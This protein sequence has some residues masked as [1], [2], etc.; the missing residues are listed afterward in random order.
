MK[1]EFD[2]VE[3]ANNISK[4]ITLL[5]EGRKQ[6]QDKAEKRANAIS[7]YDLALMKSIIQLKADDKYPTTLIEKI[8]KGECYKER[9]EMEL[10]EAEY[11]LTVT[12]MD[13]IRAEL[14]GWQSISKYLD[15][16]V[17]TPSGIR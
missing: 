12:K 5:E 6:L 10:R 17:D 13:A 2:V 4:K 14:N 15:I 11:K 3:V 16:S 9:A 1:R 7:A 8:A